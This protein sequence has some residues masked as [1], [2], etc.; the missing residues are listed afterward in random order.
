MKKIKPIVYII[1]AIV[2]FVFI[3]FIS[4]NSE[5]DQVKNDVASYFSDETWRTFNSTEGQFKVN[6]PK[7]PSSG[8]PVTNESGGV[9]YVSTEYSSTGDD[10]VFYD[11]T[12][13]Y[14]PDI[15]SG[16]Y[17]IK[18]GLEGSLNGMVASYKT[19]ELLSSKFVSFGK[20]Q[21]VDYEIYN[22]EENIYMRGRIII[23]AKANNPVKIYV[24]LASSTD[25]TPNS[26][27]DKFINSFEILE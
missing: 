21:G 18:G 11:V 24:L 13:G 23:V 16:E 10:D 9:K 25:K 5:T 26:N 19:N 6:F 3:K 14:Y 17:S 8:S 2:A 1:I 4:E 20:Y 7:Y 15:L 27:F 12:Y 22:K